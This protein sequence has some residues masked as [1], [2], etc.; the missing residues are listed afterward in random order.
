[1]EIYS[2]DLE[3][4]EVIL[5]ETHVNNYIMRK[6]S[7]VIKKSLEYIYRLNTN[8]NNYFDYLKDKNYKRVSH[9]F[10]KEILEERNRSIL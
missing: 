8:F 4:D 10:I 6:L 5:K 3:F 2:Y 1:M 9:S 7:P